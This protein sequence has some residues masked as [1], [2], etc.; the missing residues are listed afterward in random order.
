VHGM[1]V[2]LRRL[3]R[4]AAE[5]ADRQRQARRLAIPVVEEARLEAVDAGLVPASDGWFVVNVADAAWMTNEK[6][7]ARGTF[8]AS[9]RVVGGHS[10]LAP[11]MFP[12]LG[13]MLDVIWPGQPDR[14]S[15]V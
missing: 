14:K 13:L 11:V 10:E 12:Q 15:V 4:Q 9:P 3:Q 6:F 2:D 1:E 8:E 5:G 7:G